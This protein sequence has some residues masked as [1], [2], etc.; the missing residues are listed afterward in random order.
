MKEE[1]QNFFDNL[2]SNNININNNSNFDNISS[3]DY[4]YL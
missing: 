3:N 2:K 1:L 4:T